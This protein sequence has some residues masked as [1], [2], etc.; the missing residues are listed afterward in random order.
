MGRSFENRKHSIMKTA[1]MKSRLYSRYGKQLYVTARNGVPDPESNPALR[2]LIEKAKRDQVPAHVIDNAIQKAAGVGG[3]DF[4]SARYEGFGPGGCTVIIECLTDNNTRTFSEI[5]TC[6]TRTDCKLGA[7]GSVV[8]LFDN[9]AV[10]RFAGDDE[11]AVLEALLNAD[12]DVTE[13]E[14]EDG[15]I[16][17]YAPPDE[18]Y[19]A[20]TALQEAMPEI[21]FEVQEITF[22]PQ[23]EKE[24]SADDVPVFRKFMELVNDCDDVQEVYHNAILPEES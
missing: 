6:F 15:R 13:V 7:T 14:C 2:S 16:T 9:L 22:L 23:A 17:V 18:F 12:V 8:H 19:K 11:E 1:G 10:L 4:Q 5:R 20:K 24:I 3:E 21:E